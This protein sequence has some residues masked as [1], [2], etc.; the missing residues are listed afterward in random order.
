MRAMMP[1]LL[2]VLVIA[3]P[4]CAQADQPLA[5][6]TV[7]NG[8]PA[9]VKAPYR[10]IFNFDYRNTFVDAEPVRFYGLRIGAQRG[11]DLL[12]VGFYGL[13]DAYV[14]RQVP[15]EGVGIR[16]HLIDFDY[17]A[18]SYE[19]LLVN[20]RS[21]DIG[22]PLS[23]GLGT[24]RRSYINE[25]NKPVPY[26]VNELVPLEA[27]LQIDLKIFKWLYIGTGMGYRHVL[28]ADPAASRTLS[29]WTWYGKVGLRLGVLVRGIINGKRDRDG[30]EQ[31]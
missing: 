1:V 4:A 3:S 28:A 11:R 10:V 7:Q 2:A 20:S 6:S 21:W 5:P 26:A 18:L 17:V 27:T 9:K 30:E 29:D 24:Y 31:R 15:V 23:I 12:A 16:D 22:I 13:G 19:R 8:K 25:D 14:Q